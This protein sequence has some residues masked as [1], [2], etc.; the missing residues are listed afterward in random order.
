MRCGHEVLDQLL[1]AQRV[2][3]RRDHGGAVGADR[4]CV[5]RQRGRLGGRLCAAVDDQA[6]AAGRPVGR[7]RAGALVVAE[8][9]ALA[10]GATAE[11]AV[12]AALLEVA[13]QRRDRVR[14]ERGA[15]V[16]ERGDGGCEQWVVHRCASIATHAAHERPTRPG[17]PGGDRQRHRRSGHRLLRVAR[18]HLRAGGRAPAGA[19]LDDDGRSPWAGTGC[20][21]STAR[22]WSWCGRS[23]QLFERF[24][25][26]TGQTLHDPGLRAQGYLWLA[27]T[28]ATAARQRRAGGA[29]ARVGR[30][31]RRAP[32]R[33]RGPQPL[34]RGCPTTWLQARFRQ[35]DGLIEPKRIAMGLL[36]GSSADVITGVGVTGFEV[37]SRPADGRGHRPRHDRGRCGRD[38]RRA[39]VRAAVRG[40]PGWSCPSRRC[41]GSGWCCGTCRRCRA[42]RP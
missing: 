12:D 27:R 18:R 7:R 38:C 23:V 25:E 37:S 2:V 19:V 22:S 40:R 1:A 5:S 33:R 16:A 21:S 3:G 20:S 29:P 35:G 14:V 9:H 42:T 8:Q 6:A 32:D 39:V 26:E 17:R 36:E 24:A 30:G 11:D 13:D 15:V 41:D 4:G 34:R 31:R 28:E 10:G